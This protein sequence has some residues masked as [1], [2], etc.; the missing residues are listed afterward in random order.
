MG[1]IWTTPYDK[2]NTGSMWNTVALDIWVPYGWPIW[3]PYR[4]VC[5]VTPVPDISNVK[6]AFYLLQVPVR[7]TPV[8]NNVMHVKNLNRMQNAAD[9]MGIV[10]I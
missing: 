7:P 4:H 1:P 2:A 8:I 3:N 9:L 10:L 6:H 5:W